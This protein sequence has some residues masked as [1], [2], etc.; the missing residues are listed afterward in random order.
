MI[1]FNLKEAVEILERTPDVLTSLLGNLPDRWIYNN[2]G[3]ESWS[4]FDIVGHLI[5]G[6]KM[7]WIPRAKIIL[8][9]GEEKPFEPF[10]RF[11]QFN[12]S[13][14]KTLNNLLEEFAKLRYVNI[15]VLKKLNLDENDFNKKGIHPEFGKVTLK[16]LFST[17][18]VH[19]LSHIRQIS[20][21]MAKQYKN[22]IGP[23]EKYL[24]VINE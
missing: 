15:D 24:P 22:E 21:V 7:D 20:R 17:W 18:V 10:D 16:Q 9:C 19:D 4:P 3:G 5:H 13:K 2:E 1:I 8:E 6:E 11:A 23:W 12:D 14:G